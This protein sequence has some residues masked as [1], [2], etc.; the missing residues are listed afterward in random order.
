M[1]KSV[2]N[3]SICLCHHHRHGDCE[4]VLLFFFGD[5]ILHIESFVLT[6]F[7]VKPNKESTVCQILMK[8]KHQ[9]QPIKQQTT[10]P[11]TRNI[12]AIKNTDKAHKRRT[13]N[14]RSLHSSSHVCENW[15]NRMYVKL[16]VYL[17]FCSY[18]SS[19][20]NENNARSP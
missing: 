14:W 18:H 20:A 8:R 7:L 2:K 16:G 15:T 5:Q 1:S 11:R 3:G 10:S 9:N 12:Q 17:S 6:L 19:V 4:F 13:F